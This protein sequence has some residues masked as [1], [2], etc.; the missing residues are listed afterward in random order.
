[1][2]IDPLDLPILLYLQHLH[3][4]YPSYLLLHG[5]ISSRDG[6]RQPISEIPKCFRKQYTYIDTVLSTLHTK[7]IYNVHTSYT[8]VMIGTYM[9]SDREEINMQRS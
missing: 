4:A 2:N 5:W 3:H 7:T 8:V 1:M 9:G 6:S